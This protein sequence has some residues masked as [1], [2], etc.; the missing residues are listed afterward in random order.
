MDEKMLKDLVK[1]QFART[2]TAYV[3]SETHSD[4]EELGLLVQWLNPDGH[5]TVL[6]V[7][8]GGGHVAKAVSPCVHTVFATD[9]TKE[10]LIAAARHLSNATVSNAHYVVADA[11][12]LPFLDTTFDAV[13]CRIA[14]HHFVHPEQFVR[15]A[16][17][18]LKPSGRFL[19]V[20]NVAPQAP[21]LAHFLNTF[22][23]MRDESH[24]RCASVQEWE[25]WLTRC[26]F[27]IEKSRTR[28]KTI[29]YD[30]WIRRMAKSREQVQKVTSYLLSGSEAAKE[31]FEIMINDGVITSLA[32]DEWM[33]LA[34]KR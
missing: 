13:T 27:Q 25:T 3:T 26:G 6:D 20:D 34:V 29:Q 21:E 30:P 8:T 24:V 15:E 17:R 1:D 33:A 10:M 18:V 2:A 28:R 19:L 7:A 14:P 5:W 9:I 4:S 32:L 22:E 31:Y 12:S 11:E 16:F 23:H